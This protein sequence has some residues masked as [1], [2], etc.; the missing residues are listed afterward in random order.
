MVYIPPNPN[1]QA[2]SANSAPVVIASDQSAATVA[3]STAANLQTTA[4]L[5]SGSNTIGKVNIATQT[6]GGA[7][8]FTLVSAAT[9][10]ATSVKTSAG[11]LLMLVATNNGA[12][13]AFLKLYNK[14]SAPTV[15]TDTPVMTIMLPA[16]GG[17][18]LPIPAAGLAFSTGIAYALTGAAT[19]ADTTAVA[20]SQIQVNG[21]YA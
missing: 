5:A 2:T 14:A 20:L 18:A 12:S 3:Q 16:S 17:V 6:T 8:T 1:G 10:N 9:T 4:T 7:T 21:A 11:T 19:T 13:V 15:G